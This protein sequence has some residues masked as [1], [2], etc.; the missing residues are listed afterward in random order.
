MSTYGGQYDFGAFCID[1]M[2]LFASLLFV[3][4][5]LVYIRRR[6]KGVTHA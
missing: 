6:V 4:L 3:W 5:V 1:M 2:A